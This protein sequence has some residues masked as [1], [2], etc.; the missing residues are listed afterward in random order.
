MTAMRKTKN[1]NQ[2]KRRRGGKNIFWL[3]KNR[4]TNELILFSR[5]PYLMHVPKEFHCNEDLQWFSVYSECYPNVKVAKRMRVDD[6]TPIMVKL[7]ICDNEPDMY[8]QRYKDCLFINSHL[9]TYYIGGKREV[10]KVP[11]SFRISNKL[12]PDV[13]EESGIVGVK[14]VSLK[15]N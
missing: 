11:H 6:E 3:V 8:I 5:K 7:A 13:T 10:T 14:I 2:K 12:F 4:R 9:L 15:S 1:K